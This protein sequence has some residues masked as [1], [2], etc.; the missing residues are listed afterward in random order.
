MSDLVQLK[1]SGLDGVLETL[2][3]LP[4]EIVSKGGGPV[5]LA[6]AKG[7]RM[8]RDAIKQAAP[9]D[10]GTL[11]D[12]IVSMRG[13]MRLGGGERQ[14]VRVMPDYGQYANTRH[15][16]RKQQVG[17]LYEMGGPAYYWR[18]IEYGTKH[19]A[20]RPFIRPTGAANAQRVI[21]AVSSDLVRRVNLIKRKL[22]DK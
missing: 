13:A 17:K 15:N 9:V 2:R 1:V 12:N 16:R 3:Q 20:A 19:Q 21:D 4:P 5:K 22:G 8:L 6:L 10:T 7:A 14:V 11:R 18:F